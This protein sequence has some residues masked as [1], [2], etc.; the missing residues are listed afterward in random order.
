MERFEYAVT[1]TPAEE[2]GFAS[3][4]GASEHFSL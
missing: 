2:G 1:L 3:D 4:H